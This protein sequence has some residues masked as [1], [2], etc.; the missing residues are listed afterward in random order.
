[1]FAN[2]IVSFPGL[3]IGD[4]TVNNEAVAIGDG[5]AIYWYGIIITLGIITAFF[6]GTYRGKFEGIDFDTCVDVALFTVIFGVI[7]ARLYYVLAELDQFIPKPFNLFEF[8]ANVFNVRGGGL[9]IYGGIIGGILGILATTTYK[10]IKFL[11]L[12]DMAALGVMIAQSMGRWGNFFNGEAY[13]GIVPESHPLYFLRMGL[14]SPN[15]VHDFNTTAMVYVHPT[16]LYESLWNLTGFILINFFYKRKKFNGQ[17]SCM[18]LAWYG[19]GRMFIEALR[20]DSLYIPGTAI[21]ISQLVGFLC[22]VVFGALLIWGLIYS[23]KYE[24]EGATMNRIDAIIKPEMVENPHITFKN[25]FDGKKEIEKAEVAQESA[26]E[27]KKTEPTKEEPETE[28]KE[29]GNDN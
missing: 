1:M 5:F 22:F 12:T 16:F 2:T 9:A 17:I 19:F 24:L 18:Y 4:F 26:V 8:I 6:Y 10:K 7:G 15:T 25:F 14:I 13:G 20:T 27:C 28:D 29:N 3:G 23:K 11:K 21:R